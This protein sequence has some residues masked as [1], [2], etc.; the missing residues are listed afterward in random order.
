MAPAAASTCVSHP[1]TAAR[2]QCDG[3]GKL[4]CDA[5]IEESHRLLLCRLCG[6][7]ALPLEAAAPATTDERR[8]VA[9][10][11]A[12]GPYGIGK[13]LLYPFRGSGLFLFIAS[14]LTAAVVTFT[15]RFGFGCFPIFLWICWWS[16]LIGIQFKIVESTA[17]WENE[18]PDWPEYL[19]FGERVVEI[20]TYLVIA[21]L[22]VGPLFAFLLAFG[23]KGLGTME[24]SLGF[25]L[26]AAA[27]L[28]LGTALSVMAWGSA[29]LHWRRSALRVD[30]HVKA[31]FKTG[32]DGLKTVNITFVLAGVVVISRALMSEHL[33]LLGVVLSGVLGIYWTFV[34][35]HLVG[36]LFRRHAAAMHA[37]Y[38]G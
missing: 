15:A 29:A 31:L 24:P 8:K 21:L 6:E 20:L 36:L 32:G 23:I 30:N 4:L 1:Q 28:W 2:F 14:L 33:P 5:C 13:A 12:Q 26:G 11:A 35:P 37:L 25:W 17:K 22:Q 38:E 27:T 10:V 9:R 16:L 34:A 19:S 3:C 18:L 7:R